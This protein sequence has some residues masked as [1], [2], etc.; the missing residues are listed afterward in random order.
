ML[1][2]F[3]FCGQI[4]LL[5]GATEIKFGQLGSIGSSILVH[6][7]VSCLDIVAEHKGGRKYWAPKQYNSAFEHEMFKTK[8]GC[9]WCLYSKAQAVHICNIKL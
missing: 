3:Q 4:L 2:L 7:I 1:I 9:V 8:G 6:P 5:D